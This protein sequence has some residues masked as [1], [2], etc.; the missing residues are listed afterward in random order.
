MLSIEIRMSISGGKWNPFM[1]PFKA[2]LI[3]RFALSMLP[4]R[5]FRCSQR[6][7]AHLHFLAG[8]IT[9][10]KTVLKGSKFTGIFAFGKE[11]FQSLRNRAP[12]FQPGVKFTWRKALQHIRFHCAILSS[13]PSPLPPQYI[14]GHGLIWGTNSALKAQTRW[15]V[16][17][18]P[19]S[20]K[21]ICRGLLGWRQELWLHLYTDSFPDE[22]SPMADRTL[23]GP[24]ASSESVMEG[25][26][27]SYQLCDWQWW[28]R[29][30]VVKRNTFLNLYIVLMLGEVVVLEK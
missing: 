5:P 13:F 3:S 19:P 28:W 22:I 27:F 4:S 10:D 29:G 26:E 17:K 21:W 30:G 6:H 15:Y 7:Q 2:T 23:C 18:I 24:Q 12:W 14:K 20:Q 16:L 25:R 11:D 9:K 1:S 8:V